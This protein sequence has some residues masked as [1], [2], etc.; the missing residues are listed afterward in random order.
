MSF[1]NQIFE[2]EIEQKKPR[3]TDNNIIKNIINGHSNSC[4]VATKRSSRGFNY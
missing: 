1:P 3:Q 4:K 2:N